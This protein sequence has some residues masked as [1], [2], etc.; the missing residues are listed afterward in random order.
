MVIS[1][2]FKVNTIEDC[3]YQKF[4][5]SK[6]MFLV[7]Y[8]NDISLTI[9]DIS[10]LHET[11]KFLSKN[12]EM[13]DIGV[14]SFVLRIQIHRNHTQGTLGLSQRNYIKKVL[15]RFDT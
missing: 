7:L 5:G 13:K 9:N 4:S 14:A 8:V 15:K 11:K 6:F 12:F 10:M 1:F 3:V 2:N